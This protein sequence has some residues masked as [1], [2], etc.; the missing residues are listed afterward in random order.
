MTDNSVSGGDAVRDTRLYG[1]DFVRAV[2]C[3]MV[4]AHHVAQRV[5]PEVLGTWAP[6]SIFVQ[7]FAFGVGAFFVLSG[8]LLSRPFWRALDEGRAMPDLGTY[9]LRRAARI[10]P[11]FWLALTVSFVLSF[12]V[13]GATLDWTLVLRFVAGLAFVADFHWLTWF[14]VEFN[15]PLWSIG[16]EVTSYALMPLCLWLLFGRAA[17]RG[18]RA[19][20]VVLGLIAVVVGLQAV[21]VQFPPE[22][23][24]RGW[25]YGIVGGAKLWWP[26][27]NPI[28]FFATFMVGALAAGVQVRLG[29]LKSVWF[30][31]LA[32]AGLGLAAWSLAL[33]YP[34]ADAYGLAGIPYGFP[35]FPLGVGLFLVAMPAARVLPLLT[36]NGLVAY[37]AKVSFGVYVWH[38][39]LMEIVRV[40]WNPDYVYWGMRDVGQ[41]ALISTAVLALAFAIATL[42]YRWVEEPAMRWARRLEGKRAGAPTLSPAAG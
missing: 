3:L 19:R 5:S 36:E 7:M 18:W 30:D 16:C 34:V 32:L 27:Y 6:V 41:W 8:Y 21:L 22:R 33:S 31:G 28:G 26:N 39:L 14:P 17:L 15:A 10:V 11:G 24:G 25:E 42:S 38:Y 23:A 9:A 20:L 40:L 12:T 13:L 37:V 4:L 1:A 2:A 35:L 29:A